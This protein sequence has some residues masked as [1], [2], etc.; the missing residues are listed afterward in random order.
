MGQK[1]QIREENFRSLSQAKLV[2][3]A[4][5]ITIQFVD[6][7]IFEKILKYGPLDFLIYYCNTFNTSHKYKLLLCELYFPALI[8]KHF[9]SNTKSGVSSM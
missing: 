9:H 1:N 2:V 7:K 3:A 4:S 5:T 8:R 6:N